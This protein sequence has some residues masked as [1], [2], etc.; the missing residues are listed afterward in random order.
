MKKTVAFILTFAVLVAL[1]SLDARALEV[2]ARGAVLMCVNNGEVLYSKN[3]DERLS[4]ASTTKIMT[5]LLAIEAA[6]P[7]MEITVTSEMVSVEG[8]SMG[9]LPGDSV[10]MRELIYG[11][12]LQ[13]GNDAAHTA[14]IVLGGSEEAFA[15]MMN[16]R[17]REIG[18]KN[19]VFVTAS[20]LDEENHRSTAYDMAL[21]ACESIKNPEFAAICSSKTATL[22]YGNPPYKRT[23]RNHNRL[24][25]S[26]ESV[27]GIKTGFTKK[28]GRC[29]VSAAQRDGVTLVAVTLN[30]P[31]DW[32]DHL[33]MLEYGFDRCKA[34]PVEVSL[35]GLSV[36]VCGGVRTQAAVKPLGKAYCMEGEHCTVEVLLKRMEY[37]PVSEGDI[38]G[39]AIFR[40]G[41]R[42]VAS[43]PLA[44]AESVAYA[45]IDE[46]TQKD[47]AFTGVIKKIKSFFNKF[48]GD[49][50]A[51]Q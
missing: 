1:Y 20:G 44:A 17:A 29:L 3:A 2:S 11:M 33:T 14:A 41:E 45:K 26:D 18:M 30:A 43:V 46:E 47:G 49:S 6:V 9:L 35:G 50:I 39:T 24:L 7:D 40:C 23:L 19:T 5:A 10:S 32:N 12:L 38:L 8:T 28:S 42:T 37:A 27:I 22:T 13:S 15:E 34:V 16:E 4:M 48:R 25:W 51:R 31:D 36:P 21:L